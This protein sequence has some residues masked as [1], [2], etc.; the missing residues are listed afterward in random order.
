MTTAIF[1]HPACFGHDNGAN[2]PECPERLSVI[3]EALKE[4]PFLGLTWCRSPKASPTQLARF[5]RKQYIDFVFQQTP[6]NIGYVPL[7][8]DTRLSRGSLDAALHAAGAALAAVD[9]V[10]K[11]EVANAFCV[12]RPP[13]HHALSDKAMGFCLFNN[14]ALAA[15][16]ALHQHKLKRVAIIDFDVHHGN[17]TEAFA[18]ENEGVFFCSSHQA[19]LWPGTGLAEDRGPLQNILNIPLPIGSKGGL[20]RERLS[21]QL[22]PALEHYAPELILISAGF[23]AH[24][25]D[26]LANLKL[27]A[28][29][30][31]WITEALVDIAKR[32]AGGRIVSSLEGGYNLTALADCAAAH[33]LALM[34]SDAL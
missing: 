29:D 2:H 13:G 3:L 10:I 28:S 22:L 20:F 18:R 33:T 31:A 14:I 5:H 34:R 26:P 30:F 17:G 1:T 27:E 6:K 9:A 15:A 24:K 7:D 19:P 12:V 8:D 21:Q 23:D 25:T 4:P 16:H 11:K 32:Y